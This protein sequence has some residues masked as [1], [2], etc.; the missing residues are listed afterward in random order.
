MKDF[1]SVVVVG[2]GKS[3]TGVCGKENWDNCKETIR[4]AVS[5]KCHCCVQNNLKYTT[6][7]KFLDRKILYVFLN[8]N[9]YYILY[10]IQQKQ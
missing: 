1:P 10:K 7:Q 5:G 8:N 4:A 6:S 3:G 9:N 2:L